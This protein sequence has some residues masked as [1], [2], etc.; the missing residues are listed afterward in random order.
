MIL[1]A[2]LYDELMRMTL[3]WMS[4][5][6]QLAFYCR[7]AVKRCYFSLGVNMAIL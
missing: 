2:K 5:S 4:R 3:A 7:I 1:F 6:M